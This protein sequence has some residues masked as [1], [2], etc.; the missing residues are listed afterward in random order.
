LSF[1][2]LL[3]FSSF[4]S[5]T[6]SAQQSLYFFFFFLF[7]QICNT[8]V[9]TLFFSPLNKLRSTHYTSSILLLFVR[10]CNVTL[11][12]LYLSPLNKFQSTHYS[13]SLL[14]LLYVILEN[15]INNIYIYLLSKARFVFRCKK[16]I[17]RIDSFVYLF[18]LSK[19][20]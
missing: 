16:I 12:S 17:S 18:S 10:I 7:L 20:N 13:F 15:V 14:Y 1:L 11:T 2:F 9:T 8:V 6:I 4:L 3:L 19:I 5:F